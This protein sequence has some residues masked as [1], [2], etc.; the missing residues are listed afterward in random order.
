MFELTMIYEVRN[1]HNLVYMYDVQGTVVNVKYVVY[2]MHCALY[3]SLA[4]YG[5]VTF[6]NVTFVAENTE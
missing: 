1:V 3:H 6:V 4:I 2:T 5:E